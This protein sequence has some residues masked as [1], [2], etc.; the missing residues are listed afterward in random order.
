M[1]TR[2]DMA[3]E[4]LQRCPELAGVAEENESKGRMRI[5]RIRV[6]T[7]AASRKL[8]KPKGSYITLTLPEDGLS[9]R[10]VRQEAGR[11]VAAEL[12]LLM[13]EVQNVLVVYV[14][15]RVVVCV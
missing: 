6:R 13:G 12:S 10:E 9:S 3:H 2:T 7:Q 5:S 4:A 14:P 15:R 1:N 11:C 8:D